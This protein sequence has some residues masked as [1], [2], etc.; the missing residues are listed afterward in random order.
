MAILAWCF[1]IL[2]GAC[3]VMGVLTTVEVVPVFAS[4]F[5]GTFWL[6]LSVI[7]FLICIAFAVSSGKQSN[8]S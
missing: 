4:A 7:L 6:E 3:A 1:G 2:G 5:T 8:I